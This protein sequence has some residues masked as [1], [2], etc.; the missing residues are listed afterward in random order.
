M[1]E[2]RSNGDDAACKS[3]KVALQHLARDHAR[4]PMQWDTS[5]NAGFSSGE[6]WMRVNDDYNVCNAAE[7][8]G[9]KKSVLACW[10]KMLQLRKQL[11]DL[12]VYGDFDMLDV[13]DENCFAFTKTYGSQKALA[14]FNFTDSVQPFG[15]SES[16]KVHG[17]QLVADTVDNSEVDRLEPFEGRLYMLALN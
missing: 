14:V 2:K 12:L 13:K 9:N 1:V 4:V 15:Y 10:K 16:V 6:P 3:A 17:A 7:Q 8:Q 11:S 5:S